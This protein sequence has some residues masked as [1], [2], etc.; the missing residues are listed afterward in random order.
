[1]PVATEIAAFLREESL[2]RFL[3]YV[4]VHTTSD[5]ATGTNPSSAR[6][7]DLARIVEGE[8]KE[9]GV[10]VEVDEFCYLYAT[11]PQSDG[12]TGPA[13][14]FIA[15]F[16]TSP[17]VS[18]ENV[19]PVIHKNYDG[20][21]I[22]FADDPNLVLGPDDSKELLEFVGQDIITASGT[23]LLGADDKAGIAAI[24]GALEI[25]VQEPE[26]PRPTLRVCFNADEEIGRGADRFPMA[27]FDCPVAF[28]V[29]GS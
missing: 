6:Q 3:R 25:L 23:T 18:G 7:F 5:E 24:M 4:T 22:L 26:I 15:H 13:T 29:D 16:D 21:K 9:L 12:A 8:L 19:R 27:R 1:M 20:G 28:T 11:L 14:G 2:K 10:A 17:A